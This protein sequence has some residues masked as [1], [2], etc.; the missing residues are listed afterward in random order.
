MKV[1]LIS[2]YEALINGI[3]KSAANAAGLAGVNWTQA[4]HDDLVLKLG[5]IR[6]AEI[7]LYNAT[8]LLSEKVMNASTKLSILNQKL[9]ILG[10]ATAVPAGEKS[11]RY[12]TSMSSSSAL[13]WRYSS[14]SVWVTSNPSCS[15]PE[16]ESTGAIISRKLIK[17]RKGSAPS[18]PALK[19]AAKAAKK[20]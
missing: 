3:T 8:H 11:F 10:A 4:D 5:S 13:S 17:I 16:F 6:D 9:G 12:S 14:G 7:A 18:L 15:V 2:S 20:K 1:A 19:K